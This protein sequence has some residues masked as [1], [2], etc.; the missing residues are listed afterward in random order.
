MD[1]YVA[2]DGDG[3]GTQ[4]ER[5]ALQDDVVKLSRISEGIR[6]AGI[7][8][9]SFAI[10]RG[11][12]V[13]SSGGDEGNLLIPASAVGELTKLRE[14]YYEASG[15]TLS[16]GIGRRLSEAGKALMAAKIR[17]KDR[18]VMYDPAI[19]E[20]LAELVAE[21]Q[22][23]DEK[24][25][26]AYL[27]GEPDPDEGDGEPSSL[28]QRLRDAIGRSRQS[29]QKEDESPD[30]GEEEAQTDEPGQDGP[31]PPEGEGDPSEQ[32]GEGEGQPPE[33]SGGQ[34]EPGAGSKEELQQIVAGTLEA[35]NRQKPA[36][37]QLA[38]AAP[39]VYASIVATVQT[40]LELARYALGE[41]A[42]AEGQ[43]DQEADAEEGQ[44]GEEPGG[45]GEEGQKEAGQESG[46][47][48]EEEPG[49][50]EPPVGKK[51]NPVKK[52]ED[53]GKKH[54][55]K[56][57]RDTMK[58]HCAGAKVMG[59]MDHVR[60]AEVLGKPVPDG[61]TCGKVEKAGLPL[62]E[63]TN[64]QPKV[65]YP[66][67]TTKGGQ[68]KIVDPATGKA[69]WSSLTSGQVK[70][71]SGQAAPAGP[72]KFVGMGGNPVDRQGKPKS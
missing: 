62:P 64:K 22:P 18:V 34:G 5:A 67:G 70:G 28:R 68:K 24:I 53:V 35:M 52:A 4:V 46:Q 25:A 66:A 31:V 16:V 11:G 45:S 50:K 60:A 38:E 27:K 56:I 1:I 26:E 20:E 36:L 57:A 10:E 29:L 40:M 3:I 21:D 6:R 13:I 30:P 8:M 61:C 51:G 17:G 72:A 41:E 9:N 23:E 71:P 42:P 32:E 65:N 33:Q 54:Q 12:R 55:L 59:G 19:D 15:A 69:K 14:M 43:P 7:I 44:P 39:E 58:M 47:E 63:T 48:A 2:Y 37:E 49:E